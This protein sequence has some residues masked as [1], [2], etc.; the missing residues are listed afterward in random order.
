MD[1]TQDEARR[2]SPSDEVVLD[3]VRDFTVEAISVAARNQVLRS[4][5]AYAWRRADAE[6]RK[7]ANDARVERE[8]PR[9][10]PPPP[11]PSAFQL[12]CI[13]ARRR[14]RI[15]V[16]AAQWLQRR[17]PGSGL[18]GLLVVP[19]GETRFGM[20][21]VSPARERRRRDRDR[22]TRRPRQRRSHRAVVK[23]AAGDSGDSD[24]EPPGDEP[25]GSWR[26]AIGG[27][28]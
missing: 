26:I 12:S 6:V 4:P 16:A 15:E 19:P 1:T 13:A 3:Y 25:P 21:C 20:T 11:G 7:H 28:P 2:L 23:T 18:L 17:T 9:V 8:Q 5:F 27:A 14:D 24:G 22:V 10:W